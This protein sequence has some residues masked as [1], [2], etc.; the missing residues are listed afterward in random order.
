M[1]KF[2]FFNVQ[3]NAILIKMDD[4]IKI[5]KIKINNNIQITIDKRIIIYFD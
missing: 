1:I 3:R 2:K 5:N 4:T